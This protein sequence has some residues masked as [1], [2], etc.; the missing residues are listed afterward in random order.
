MPT[1]AILNNMSVEFIILVYIP[2]TV[3]PSTNIVGE[4]VE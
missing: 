1:I 4:L 2:P 3:I